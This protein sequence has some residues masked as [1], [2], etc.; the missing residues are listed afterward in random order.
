MRLT[1]AA[2]GRAK[3]GAL[4]DAY[5]DYAARLD[6]GPRGPLG[7]LTLKEVEERRPLAPAELKRREAELLLGAVPKGARL[8]ALDERGKTMSSED[9]ARVLGRWRDDGV[10]EAAFVIGGAEGLDETV[11]TAADLVLSLGPMTWPHM[12]VRV[13]LAEQLY[14]TQ[15]ILTGHPYHR[16]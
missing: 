7:P 10:A 9:F 8:I 13:L 6:Q 4:R 5:R 3:A 11:R 1:L 14:R 15:S 12:L 16:G 2:V